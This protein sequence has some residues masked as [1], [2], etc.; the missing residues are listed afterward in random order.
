MFSKTF[1]QEQ[2]AQ[3]TQGVVMAIF[4]VSFYLFFFYSRNRDI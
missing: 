2:M 4:W 3:N 1:F